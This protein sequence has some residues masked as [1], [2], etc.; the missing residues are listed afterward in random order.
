MCVCVCLCV[1][2]CML[3]LVCMIVVWVH[4]GSCVFITFRRTCVIVLVPAVTHM[5][6]IVTSY[7]WVCMF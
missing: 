6:A 1:C 5:E 2:M 4:D 3:E 7:L